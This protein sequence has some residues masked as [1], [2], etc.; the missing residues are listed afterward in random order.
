MLVL[1]LNTL[2]HLRF[3]AL[4]PL[5]M[6]PGMPYYFAFSQTSIDGRYVSFLYQQENGRRAL[7]NH[8]NRIMLSDRIP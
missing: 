8:H 7:K 3:V 1:I 6:S 4:S 2:S 5:R